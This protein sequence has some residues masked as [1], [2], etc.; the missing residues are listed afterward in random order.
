MDSLIIKIPE[1]DTYDDAYTKVEHYLRA[2]R[3]ENRRI[4]SK[5]VYVILEKAA[6]EHQNN[7]SSDIAALAMEETYKLTS[8]WCKNVL[9]LPPS[10]ESE[11]PLKDKIAM[12]LSNVPTKWAKYFLSDDKLPEGLVKA[13]KKAYLTA[14]PEFQRARMTHRALDFNPAAGVLAETYKLANKNPI[15][16]WLIY[17]AIIF[18]FALIFF[19]TR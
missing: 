5:S 9:D 17:G 15:A 6:A 3:I 11:I 2:L 13:M 7:P 18:I 14:G 19:L 8:R 16:K 10:N 1:T 12:L 4:L